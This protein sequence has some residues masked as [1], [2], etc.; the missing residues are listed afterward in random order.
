MIGNINSKKASEY[1][2]KKKLA[3][4]RA[5]Q[6]RAERKALEDREKYSNQNQ[7]RIQGFDSSELSEDNN[8]FQSNS[9]NM[10]LNIDRDDLP[11]SS[12]S[13]IRLRVLTPIS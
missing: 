9:Y 12:F 5:N 2:A 8:I 11:F 1:A 13:S 6:L 4:Q 7:N 3:L 10:K